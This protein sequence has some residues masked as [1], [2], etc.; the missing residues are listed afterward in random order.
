MPIG[1]VAGELLGGVLR[2]FGNIVLDVLLEV[3]IRGPGYLICR[4]F[5]KDINSE[6]GWV[7]VAGMA[8]WV[9]VAVGG[10]Y[11]YAYFSEALAIDRCLDSGG[12]F[13]Y[14]NKQCLQS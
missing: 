1:D 12:A 7:I 3:L 9:F 6:G 8:F 4:I 14:Q 11:M 2:V 13:N 10:F 5:K